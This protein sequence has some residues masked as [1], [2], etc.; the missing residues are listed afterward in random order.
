LLNV[1]NMYIDG[2]NYAFKQLRLPVN[3]TDWVSYGH[4]A[5]VNAYYSFLDNSIRKC[6]VV[7]A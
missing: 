7:V 6:L 3:K 1:L 2:K 5:D 4:P